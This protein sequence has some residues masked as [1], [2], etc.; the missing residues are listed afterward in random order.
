MPEKR[1]TG[2]ACK[3][4][5]EGLLDGTAL[6]PIEL[7]PDQKGRKVLRENRIAEAKRA[8]AEAEA[9][10]LRAAE[11]VRQ[12]K[13]QQKVKEAELKAARKAQAD[14]KKADD[15]AQRQMK[16][17]VHDAK[18]EVV[19][20]RREMERKAKEEKIEWWK[21]RELENL[22]YAYYT[23]KVLQRKHRGSIKNDDDE[24]DFISDNE[25]LDANYDLEEFQV[26][27]KTGEVRGPAVIHNPKKRRASRPKKDPNKDTSKGR[28]SKQSLLNP[29]SILT[30]EELDIL[31]A[32]RDLPRRSADETHAEVVARIAAA[33]KALST[34]DLEGLLSAAFV[35]LRG[36]HAK[37]EKKLQ[38]HDA[39]QSEAGKKGV[40]AT[41]LEFKKSYEGYY[42]KGAKFID[43]DE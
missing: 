1:Y 11:A 39:S 37:K 2:K 34:Q 16:K 31:L 30:L 9:A 22:V 24:E 18:S 6:L 41:N 5:F 25:R 26:K 38:E 19:R 10:I 17:H 7:D 12:E 20:K 3:E 28:I 8:R 43:G 36:G 35:P 29:R 4:R 15:E 13:I 14:A 21:T 40:D 33:D 27:D 32:E 23:G 42:G